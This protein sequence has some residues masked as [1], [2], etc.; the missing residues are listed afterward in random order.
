M[1]SPLQPKNLRILECVAF[2]LVTSHRP[3]APVLAGARS[4]AS[5]F[6]GERVG[7]TEKR[8]VVSFPLGGSPDYGKTTSESG[9]K[10]SFRFA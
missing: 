2:L 8:L 6:D 3:I 9:G 1:L 10:R 7:K 5:E 4:R